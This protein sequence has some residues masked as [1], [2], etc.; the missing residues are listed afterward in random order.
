[1]L[2]RFMLLVAS[3]LLAPIPT[4]AYTQ[5]IDCKLVVDGKSYVDGICEF[6][7]D[8]KAGSFSIYG[9]EYWA[10]VNVENGKGVAFWNEAPGATHAQ[11]P[12][13]EVTKKGGCWENQRTRICALAIEPSRRAKV[14]AERPN[15]LRITPTW[16]DYLC[17]SAP[18]YQ[19]IRGARLVMSG[20]D[21]F[22]GI[23][24]RMFRL[25]GDRIS[26]EGKPELCIDAR[27]PQG[28][29]DAML[30]LD[31]CSQVT[32]QWAYDAQ[33]HL[34]RSDNHLCWDI[35]VRDKHMNAGWS[36]DIVAGSCDAVNSETSQFV[37]SGD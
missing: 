24:Q 23:R 8:D 15:G 34:I 20:C 25:T 7:R 10:M 16:G 6:A 5:P 9:A 12:L 14:L 33:S 18:D 27:A 1:M 17:L 26:I 11:A 22:W 32:V 37:I 4:F 31:D 35:R 2:F 13:G 28:A 3:V 30:V 21:F 19:F 36:A 29:A